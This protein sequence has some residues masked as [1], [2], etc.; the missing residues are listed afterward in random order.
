MTQRRNPAPRMRRSSSDR[1]CSWQ[2]CALTG[3]ART[4]NKLAVGT[5]ENS[6]LG[7]RPSILIILPSALSRFEDVIVRY[8]CVERSELDRTHDANEDH[9]DEQR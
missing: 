7:L 6:S 8:L 9:N 5:A 3:A 1:R 4:T 2:L